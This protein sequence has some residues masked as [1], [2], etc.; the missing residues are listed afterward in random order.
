MIDRILVNFESFADAYIQVLVIVYIFSMAVLFSFWLKPFVYRHR[1]SYVSAGIYFI[2]RFIYYLIPVDSDLLQSISIFIV[3]I[4][5]TVAWL[6]DQKRNPIQKLFLC[7]LFYVMSFLTYEISVELGLYESR[8]VSRFD[9][10]SSDA[11][12]IAIEFIICNLIEY[13]LAGVLMF[14]SLRIILRVYKRKTEELSWRELLI[15]LT[16]SWAILIVKP[17]MLAYFRLWMDGI[18]NGSIKENIPASIYRLGFCILSVLSLVVII[19]LYENIKESEENTYARRALESQT[20]EMHRHME[21]IEETYEKMRAM[22]HDMGNHMAVVQSLIDRGDREAASDYIGNWRDNIR[23]LE[24]SVKTGN[25]FTDAA[26]T[27]FKYRFEEAGIS[28]DQSFVYP[29][30]LQ[31][32][33]FDLCVVLSN[34][35]QNAYEGSVSVEDPYVSLISVIRNNTFIIN[36]RNRIGSEVAMDNGSDVPYSSK[37]EDGHGYGLRNIRNVALKYNGDIDIRQENDG[38]GLVFILN[39]M[40]IG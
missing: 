22:R 5:C 36:V 18:S 32:N 26:I 35:L 24:S 11:R 25:P 27:G 9:W 16:P 14:F 39:V 19:M 23:E 33:P 12:A 4:S 15:L 40:M 2:L 8:F 29:E 31:V 21:Q 34:A 3:L 38:H 28:F 17:I 20:E 6:L 13:A 30:G 37:K 1:A 7:I 10:Y